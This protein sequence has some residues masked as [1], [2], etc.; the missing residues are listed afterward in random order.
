MV[1]SN[2]YAS[3]R[4]KSQHFLY[5]FV[6]LESGCFA[7]SRQDWCRAKQN[8][9]LSQDKVE[10]KEHNLCFSDRAVDR[11]LDHIGAVDKGGR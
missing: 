7:S 6:Q 2:Q 4:E 9:S 5:G 8:S 3:S 10:A 1:A 11:G